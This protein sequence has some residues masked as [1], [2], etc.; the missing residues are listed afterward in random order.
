MIAPRVTNQAKSKIYSSRALKW[1]ILCICSL[2]NFGVTIKFEKRFAYKFLSFCKKVTKSIYKIAKNA[3][4]WKITL[5]VFIHI[6]NF[7]WATEMYN[8]SF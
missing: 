5:F 6:S 2:T 1:G 8:T 4:I 3:K 7:I